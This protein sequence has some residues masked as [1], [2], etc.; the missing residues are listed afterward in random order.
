MVMRKR[1]E[2]YRM[3]LLQ[4]HTNSIVYQKLTEDIKPPKEPK[5]PK[6]HQYTPINQ[7]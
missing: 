1:G 3:S 6:V 2:R 4:A 5:Q 7:V